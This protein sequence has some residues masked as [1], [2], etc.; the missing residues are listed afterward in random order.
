MRTFFASFAVDSGAVDRKDLNEFASYLQVSAKTLSTAYVAASTRT[1]SHR[2]GKR[3]LGDVMDSGS[4]KMSRVDPSFDTGSRPRGKQLAKARDVYKE[5]I[6][7]SVARHENAN[8]C[9]KALVD[10]RREG[11]LRKT[12]EWFKFEKPFFWGHRF[13]VL[14]EV[15]P[16]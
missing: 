15:R 16:E 4:R 8:A 2:I 1:E 6:L 7:N 14:R 13:E 9:F 3:V 10:Q 11:C 12:D 5:N